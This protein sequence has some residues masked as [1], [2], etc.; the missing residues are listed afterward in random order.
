MKTCLTKKRTIP[1][2]SCVDNKRLLLYTFVAVKQKNVLTE[3]SCAR[4][5][6]WNIG[7]KVEFQNPLSK[8]AHELKRNYELFLFDFFIACS[9]MQF[10]YLLLHGSVCVKGSHRANNGK[11]RST[12]LA[13]SRRLEL[14]LWPKLKLKK[15]RVLVVWCSVFNYSR[16]S[17]IRTRW[18]QTK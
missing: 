16:T 15:K 1:A 2:R 3:W 18:D 11:Q 8:D 6:P 17:I 10:N 7:T 4:R 9:F 5:L 13:S 14:M 12:L